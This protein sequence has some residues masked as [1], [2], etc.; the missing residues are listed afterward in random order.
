LKVIKGHRYEAVIVI[1]LMLGLRRGGGSWFALVK[2][3]LD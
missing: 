2:Y 3:Q 1:A